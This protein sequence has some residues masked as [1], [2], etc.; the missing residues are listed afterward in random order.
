M[1]TVEMRRHLEPHLSGM[2]ASTYHNNKVIL[3]RC[4]GGILLVLFSPLILVLMALVRATSS[5][6]AVYK[7]TRVGKSGQVFQIY[8]LRTM[9][10]DAEKLSGPVWAVRGDSRISPVGRVLRFLHL[11]ELPQLINV[12][13]GDMSLVGPRPERPE[14]VERLARQVPRY[15]ERLAVLPG[16]TGL[17]QINLPPDEG[18]N[19][20]RRKVIIDCEYVARAS[21]LLD[22]RILIC[23]ALRML[24]V[25][26][27]RAARWL[28]IDY[29]FDDGHEGI[30]Q[31]PEWLGGEVEHATDVTVNGHSKGRRTAALSASGPEFALV[32]SS[33]AQE[34]AGAGQLEPAPRQP[35]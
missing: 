26:H 31:A 22:L 8:K 7:Q 28:K 13:R 30:L 24:G 1:E 29:K 21:F 2:A 6:A 35:R 32:A 19:C 12:L 14:F 11:D 15:K 4:I 17:A 16:I 10:Q 25:R 5:G 23:T 34:F 9:Y 27:G 20:V 33:A 3:D 18:V